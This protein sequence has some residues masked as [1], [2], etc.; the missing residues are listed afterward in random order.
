MAAQIEVRTSVPYTQIPNALIRDKRLRLQTRA[1]LIMMLSLPPDWDYSVRGMASVAG[2]SKDTMARILA[3][4]EQ[5]GYLRRQRQSR[6]EGGQFGRASFILT[7]DP[8][9]LFEDEEQPCPENPDTAPCPNLPCPEKPCPVNS[10]Q[11]IKEKQIQEQQKNPLPPKGAIPPEVRSRVD[12]YAGE[13]RELQA[14]I[15][16]LLENRVAIREPVLTTRALSGILNKLDRLSEG[17][18][19][20]KLLML[21]NATTRNW[22]TVYPL[23]LDELPAPEPEDSG[24]EDPWD[25]VC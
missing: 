25:A 24:E 14:A 2:V 12:R 8:T 17:R 22:L 19:S 1:V 5:A 18:R 7:D 3:E 23:K 10:P 11:Q 20:Y 16:G 4:L 21:E 9:A 13:D 6:G 15:L